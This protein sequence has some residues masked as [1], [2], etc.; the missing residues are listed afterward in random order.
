MNLAMSSFQQPFALNPDD[1]WTAVG[2]TKKSGK[3]SAQ[4]TLKPGFAGATKP[5]FAGATKPGFAGAT[6]SGFAEATKPVFV[7]VVKPGFV[8]AESEPSKPSGLDTTDNV[9][10]SDLA[11]VATSTAYAGSDTAS[12]TTSRPSRPREPR[13]PS[14]IYVNLGPE[15]KK[16]VRNLLPNSLAGGGK[17]VRDETILDEIGKVKAKPDVSNLEFKKIVCMI[18]HQAIKTDRHSLIERIIKQWECARYN[19]IELIDSNYDGC[20][21]MTQACWSGSMFC[22]RTIVSADPTGQILSTVHPTKGETILETLA[23]GKEYAIRKDPQ[24][25][26]FIL[27][28][29]DKCERWLREAISAHKAK[30]QAS[31]AEAA[32][33]E[34]AQ[35]D[36]ASTSSDPKIIEEIESIKLAGGDIVGE[37][38]LKLIDM[39]LTN[40]SKMSEYFE[41]VKAC[42]DEPTVE[43]IK[44][45]MGNE[46]IDL[47]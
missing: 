46:G 37:L 39:Y 6:K 42:V 43:Q 10:N 8:A 26:I 18:F 41:A 17:V 1:D 4:D 28:K 45:S 19:I 36:A 11:Q 30:V 5:G 20:K 38:S 14:G 32:Q 23:G 2:S 33:A 9:S 21:P 27:D 35:A 7:P 3:K 12:E 29:F 24:S 16:F 44:T 31:K 15:W 34:A 25:A 13:K 40:S 47:V 22:I